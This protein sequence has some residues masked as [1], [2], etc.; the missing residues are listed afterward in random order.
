[1][2]SAELVAQKSIEGLLLKKIEVILGGE[3]RLKDVETNLNRPLEIDKKVKE[4]YKSYKT[5]TNNHR[6]M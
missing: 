6:A 1:M 5:Q 4:S 3:Q 2:D